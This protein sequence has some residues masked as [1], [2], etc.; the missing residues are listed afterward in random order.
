MHTVPA[1]ISRSC[2]TAVVM[3]KRSVPA[4]FSAWAREMPRVSAWKSRY[5]PW[6]VW[7]KLWFSTHSAWA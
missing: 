3:E 5:S 6:A 2:P 7:G 1:G 4:A